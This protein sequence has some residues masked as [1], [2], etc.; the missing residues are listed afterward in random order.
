M[1]ITNK[2]G[3]LNLLFLLLILNKY[4]GTKPSRN[5]KKYEQIS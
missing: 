1:K 2:A 3:E 4:C 5:E